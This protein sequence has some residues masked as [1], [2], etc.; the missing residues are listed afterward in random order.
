MDKLEMLRNERSIILDEIRLAK[1]VDN[2]SL[3]V[4]LRIELLFLNNKIK[5]EFEVVRGGRVSVC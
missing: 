2:E 5:H 3:M 1:S 4:D